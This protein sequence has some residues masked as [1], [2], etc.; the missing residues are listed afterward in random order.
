MKHDVVWLRNFSIAT[1][2]V[3]SET[4]VSIMDKQQVAFD[5]TLYRN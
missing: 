2:D 5:S 4:R 3:A 1:T